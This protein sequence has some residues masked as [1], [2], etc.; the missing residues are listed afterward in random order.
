[1]IA[2]PTWIRSVRA[3]TYASG[4]IASVPHASAAQHEWKPSLSASTA[5]STSSSG[6][7]P[8]CA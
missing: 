3:A 1:M 6:E 4:V 2:E 8:G 5:I 7:T